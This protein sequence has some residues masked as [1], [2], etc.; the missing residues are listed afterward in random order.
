MREG[1]GKQW[2]G[3]NMKHPE[4]GDDWTLIEWAVDHSHDYCVQFL[5]GLQAMGCVLSVDVKALSHEE[6][7]AVIREVFTAVNDQSKER[8]LH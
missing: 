3:E 1:L 6:A 2:R 4:P 5:E 8:V 7:K